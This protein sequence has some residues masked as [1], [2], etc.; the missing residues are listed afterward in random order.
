[1]GEIA[2]AALNAVFAPAAWLEGYERWRTLD[3][4]GIPAR[5]RKSRC[6]PKTAEK[7]TSFKITEV[8]RFW[9]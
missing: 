4:L 8:D 9:Q 3:R 2:N 5:G 1:M 6:G 7:P